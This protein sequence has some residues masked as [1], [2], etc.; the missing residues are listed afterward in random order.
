MGSVS[1]EDRYM[2]MSKTN[3]ENL[4]SISK[5]MVFL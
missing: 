3:R 5:K 1:A 4:L 2:G